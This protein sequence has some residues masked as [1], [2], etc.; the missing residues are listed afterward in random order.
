LHA[1]ITDPHLKEYAAILM[2]SSQKLT[3]L[4]NQI[5]RSMSI[6]E[7]HQPI[8]SKSFDFC[9]S[10]QDIVGLNIAAAK[11][12]N[13]DLHFI[14]SEPQKNI[15]ISDEKRIQTIALE[16]VANAIKFTKRGKVS[17]EVHIKPHKT[18]GQILCLTVKDTGIGIPEATQEAMFMQFKRGVPSYKGTYHG[19]GLGL[20]NVKFIV[21]ELDGEITI[22]SK[23]GVG[24]TINC[25]IPCKSSLAA[26]YEND[27]I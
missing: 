4:L 23:P 27:L 24:T 8:V 16:L 22:D 15:I 26:S 12:K 21:E 17:I 14:Q 19:L 3:A 7:G 5:I 10:L 9:V 18:H 13:I 11:S 2:E 6:T 25:Y 1:K 20:Y